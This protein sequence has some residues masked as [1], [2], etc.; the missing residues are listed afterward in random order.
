MC[1][2]V[3]IYIYICIYVHTPSPPLLNYLTTFAHLLPPPFEI[4]IILFSCANRTLNA[5]FSARI[6][7]SK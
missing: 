6:P 4:E 7:V 5:T 3:Y 2:Y 1:M